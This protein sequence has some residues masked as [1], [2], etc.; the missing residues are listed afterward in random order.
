MYRTR[1]VNLAAYLMAAEGIEP[2][3]NIHRGVVWFGFPASA[4][5]LKDRY[6][7]GATVPAVTYARALKELRILIHRMTKS[8]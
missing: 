5:D 1:D 8:A 7:A 2:E 6:H 3:A 4:R